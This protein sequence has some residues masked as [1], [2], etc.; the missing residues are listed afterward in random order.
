M[1]NYLTVTVS[2]V[3]S[4]GIGLR[5]GISG[6]LANN[7]GTVSAIGIGVSGVG[8]IGLVCGVCVI[9]KRSMCVGGGN[10]GNWGSN[11]GSN[12]GNWG[13]GVT[14]IS[15]NWGSGV[16]GITKTVSVVVGRSGVVVSWVSLGLGV[17]LGLSISGA[18]SEVSVTSI[19]SI[20]VA[21]TGVSS[22]SAVSQ[23]VPVT[24]ISSE[25]VS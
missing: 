11:G 18:L 23:T 16:T 14:G 5:L 19:A 21:V 1:K 9:G 20:G 6:T 24:S 22:V 12:G 15:G 25:S 10:S 17:S 13:S 3:V 4:R 8:S 2:G 7:V